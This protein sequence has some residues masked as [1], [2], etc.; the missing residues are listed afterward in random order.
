MGKTG[1]TVT[2]SGN[3]NM[4]RY[5]Y[6]SVSSDDL[7]K[8][9]DL[10]SALLMLILF[11]AVI[12]GRELGNFYGSYEEV[13][14]LKVY[15]DVTE[16]E[17]SRFLRETLE[18]SNT[19]LK[20]GYSISSLDA[21]NSIEL[22]TI[23]P[24]YV[25]RF[26]IGVTV[27]PLTVVQPESSE[28]ELEVIVEDET[29]DL[30]LYQYP[31]EKISYIGLINRRIKIE[32]DDF[33]HF[34]SL[35]SEASD[36][37][38]GEVKVKFRGRAHV[39]LLFLDTWLPFQV[40]RYTLI[41]APHINYVDSAWMN[42]TGKVTELSSDMDSYVRVDLVNPTRIHSLNEEFTCEFYKIG[43]EEPILVVTKRVD[44]PPSIEGPYVFQFSLDDPGMY[45][46]RIISGETLL[47]ESPIDEYLKIS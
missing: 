30:D 23:Q 3:D 31:K 13:A 38:S 36:R 45:K 37:Y 35:V 28:V 19:D 2:V 25:R 26:L 1:V 6:G 40:E 21:D 10:R 47:F 4:L 20:I 16:E 22:V 12:G 14:S 5:I 32:I 43:E 44:L 39:H 42:I 46:Y 18:G 11:A 8:K 27:S 7:I 33:T 29:V 17:L 9:D 15:F 24:E 34:R 41:K